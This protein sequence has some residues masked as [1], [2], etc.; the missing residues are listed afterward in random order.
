MISADRYGRFDQQAIG[1]STS[2]LDYWTPENPTDDY[3][4]PTRNGGL[5]YMSTLNY[6]DGSYARIRNA[7]LGYTVPARI[8][9]G[10]F[11][12]GIR[13]YV[14]AKNLYTF[15]KLNYDP[16][17]GGSENFPMTKLF[18]FGLNVNL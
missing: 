3:P 5:L 16:E 4:R 15:T 17:R 1:N 10:G 14:T 13:A 9:R 6:K 2:G 18:V 7:T 11:V 12:K 8:L